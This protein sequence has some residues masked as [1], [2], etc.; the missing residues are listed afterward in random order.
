M[1]KSVGLI[2]TA[3]NVLVAAA[4]FVIS[5][6]PPAAA[7][8]LDT[9]L[10]CSDRPDCPTPTPQTAFITI[11]TPSQAEL[12]A[13]RYAFDVAGTARGLPDP[14]IVVRVRD[15]GHRIIDEQI[16]VVEGLADGEGAWRTTLHPQPHLFFEDL[17]IEA[18][19]S[20]TDEGIVAQGFSWLNFYRRPLVEPRLDPRILQAELNRRNRE[21]LADHCQEHVTWPTYTVQM[22]DSVAS[23]AEQTGA[24]EGQ[25][26]RANCLPV[27]L[28]PAIGAVLRVPRLPG[29]PPTTPTLLIDAPLSNGVLIP[30][31]YFPISGTLTNAITGTLTVRVVDTLGRVLAETNA[32]VAPPPTPQSW[33]AELAVP[34]VD[35]GTRALVYAYLMAPNAHAVVTADGVPVI[36]GTNEPDA[37]LAIDA[38]LPYTP[39]D[40]NRA[41]TVRGRGKYDGPVIVEAVDSATECTDAADAI[42]FGPAW[43]IPARKV[44]A[45]MPAQDDGID[46]YGEKRWHADLTV[47]DGQR[48]RIC[49]YNR[50]WY[51]G[52]RYVPAGIDVR[53]VDPDSTQPKAQIDVPLP[54][55]VFTNREQTLHVQ[56]TAPAP[57]QFMI[58]DAAGRVLHL[59]PITPDPANGV[60]R[61]TM[62]LPPIDDDGMLT[63]QVIGA[64]SPGRTPESDRLRVRTRA[65]DALVTGVVSYTL[66]SGIPD[67]VIIRVFIDK[68]I[69]GAEPTNATLLAEQRIEADGAQPVVAFAVSYP[70][71]AI[72]PDASYV[73][74]ARIED[75]SLAVFG[76]SN[77]P[78]AVITHGAP[79]RDVEIVV[80]PFMGDAGRLARGDARILSQ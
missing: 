55:T 66:A 44:L 67:T 10:L 9:S 36:F 27:L 42:F 57:V 13:D 41:V 45:S 15:R 61:D 63:L 39:L 77:D 62:P 31:A 6:N 58:Q 4:I 26:R 46:A 5:W 23:L 1:R 47:A 17:Y 69:P 43:H 24:T 53:F 25:L 37:Y 52:P 22:G 20:D 71:A 64:A 2:L 35:S 74:S 49:V 11:T 73:L 40:T 80:Q 75:S 56:G 65:A 60:W 72:E 32:Q 16:A 76:V 79:T 19:A 28:Q 78:I 51:G 70:S 7:R 29:P 68:V 33:H 14:Q 50:V 34:D 21:E 3:G 59:A 48:A 54:E 8:T 38:P 30:N 12:P 18:V